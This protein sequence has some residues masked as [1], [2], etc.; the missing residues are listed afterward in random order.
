MSPEA[1]FSFPTHELV[2]R[3]KNK[4]WTIQMQ[5]LNGILEW[6]QWQHK[7]W[8]NGTVNW[9]KIIWAF[10]KNGILRARVE[11]QY[12]P[13]KEEA[14]NWSRHTRQRIE[15]P[16]KNNNL[17][18]KTSKWVRWTWGFGINV[19]KILHNFET[20]WLLCY[21]V[22]FLV[23]TMLM[24]SFPLGDYYYYEFYHYCYYCF[25]KND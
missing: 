14:K 5:I 18:S 2:N 19:K 4:G 20:V 23:T 22:Q 8:S 16:K 17:E 3:T 15:L 10:F 6:K 21:H 24:V 13:K 1:F 12:A 7:L 11:V 25:R 9:P